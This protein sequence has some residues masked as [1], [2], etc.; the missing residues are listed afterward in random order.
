MHEATLMGLNRAKE[1]YGDRITLDTEATACFKIFN[2][3]GLFGRLLGYW[4]SFI[5]QHKCVKLIALCC[6]LLLYFCTCG[7]S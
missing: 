1:G 4:Q 2:W 6:F 5:S 3:D 7:I